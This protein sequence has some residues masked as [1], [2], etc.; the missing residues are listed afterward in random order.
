MFCASYRQPTNLPAPFHRLRSL[1]FDVHYS[2]D[3]NANTT[4]FTNTTPPR[5]LLLIAIQNAILSEPPIGIHSSITIR[6]NIEQIIIEARSATPLP[7]IIH[8]RHTGEKDDPD[9]RGTPGWQLVFPSILNEHVVDKTKDDTFADTS[10]GDIIPSDADIVIAG[11]LTNYCIRATCSA[12]LQRGNNV[13]MIR[14]THATYDAME[15]YSGGLPVPA[16][17]IERETEAE[18]EDAG[19]VLLDMLD[20]PGLF[21]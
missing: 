13:I 17:R 5:V 12:G 11:M 15:A 6:S 4:N 2:M 18:L 10:L 19:V 3:P 21:S 7:T 9:E 16:Q 8:V 14:G 1:L 20:V